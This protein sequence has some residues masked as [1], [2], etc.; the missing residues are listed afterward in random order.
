[1][2][3]R[4]LPRMKDSE[5][6]TLGIAYSLA[7]N[8]KLLEDRLPDRVKQSDLWIMISDQAQAIGR[9]Y[10]QEEPKP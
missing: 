9:N 7:S 5:L 6:S 4:Q 3:R 2:T 10:L 1:M 8:I